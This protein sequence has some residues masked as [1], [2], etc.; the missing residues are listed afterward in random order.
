MKILIYGINGYIGNL[1]KEY[2]KQSNNKIV[3]LKS[4]YQKINNK[5]QLD[6]DI[7]LLKP[8][9]IISCIGITH[10]KND[11]STS[12]LNKDEFLLENIEKNMYIHTLIS[13]TCIRNNIHFTYIGTGCI[14]KSIYTSEC[15]QVIDE[16]EPPNFFNSKYCLIKSYTDKI[17]SHDKDKILIIRLRQC[18]NSL[19][20]TNPR[21]FLNK[22]LSF[23]KVS[24]IQNSFTVIPSIFPIILDLILNKRLGIYNC[25]NKNSISV[26]E[27]NQIFNRNNLDIIENKLIY[28]QFSNNILSVKNLEEF[29]QVEDIKVALENLKIV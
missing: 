29:Y 15:N 16:E 11:N 6:K 19:D 28:N 20:D 7:N 3:I 22:F 24:N 2:F 1:L 9:R 5:D 18:I 10:N 12:F 23:N 4:L 17:L 8:D 25:V 26:K 27:I 21:N 14:Y 13:N